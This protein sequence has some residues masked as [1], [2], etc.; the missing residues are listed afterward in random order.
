MFVRQ[1]IDKKTAI[2]TVAMALTSEYVNDYVLRT[3]ANGIEANLMMVTFYYYLNIKP[4][5]FNKAL[6]FLTAAITV[7]FIIRSSSLVGFIPLALIV[8]W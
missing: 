8:I 3:S 1:L 5:M 7:S 6:S 2:C 4:V